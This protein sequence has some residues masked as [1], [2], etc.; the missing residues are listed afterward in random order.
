M[1]SGR[2]RHD[3]EHDCSLGSRCDRLMLTWTASFI[4]QFRETSIEVTPFVSKGLSRSL[5][6]VQPTARLS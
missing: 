5:V 6:K 2:K 3:P 4:A 1:T